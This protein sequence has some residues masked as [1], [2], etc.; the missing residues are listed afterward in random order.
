[1]KN[2]VDVKAEAIQRWPLATH[3]KFLTCI[4][5]DVDDIVEPG[6]SRSNDVQR[7]ERAL[8][9]K[10]L[11]QQRKYKLLLKQKNI[12]QRLIS[13]IRRFRQEDEVDN[14]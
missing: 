14:S 2:S 9:L 3:F 1:M 11:G 10:K 5:R 12:K 6:T 13:L 4:F 7:K 8:I